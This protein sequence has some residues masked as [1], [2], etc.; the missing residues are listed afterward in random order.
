MPGLC[1][2]RVMAA[3]CRHFQNWSF[4]F[5]RPKKFDQV[6]PTSTYNTHRTTLRTFA[7]AK[8]SVLQVDR[9]ARNNP[10]SNSSSPCALSKF[11]ST[12]GIFQS[13]NLISPNPF[14]PFAPPEIKPRELRL[15]H[16]KTTPRPA[17]QPPL[18]SLQP[19]LRRVQCESRPIA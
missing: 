18:Y 10:A 3:S 13:P 2:G 6:F 14:V 4:K 12:T 15:P 1:I 7:H 8:N 17:P 5:S 9:F 19:A 16:H 11:L